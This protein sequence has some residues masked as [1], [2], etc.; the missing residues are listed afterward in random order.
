MLNIRRDGIYR[1]IIHAFIKASVS[2][3]LDPG[4]IHIIPED[5]P[6][7]VRDKTKE[8]PFTGVGNQLS[9]AFSRRADMD[10]TTKSLEIA[11]VFAMARGFLNRRSRFT[12]FWERI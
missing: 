7:G 5:I 9:R 1:K 10:S 2:G 12:W 6:G 11:E 3:N 4:G 8:D